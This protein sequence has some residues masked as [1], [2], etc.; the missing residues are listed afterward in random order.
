MAIGL[1]QIS[2]IVKEPLRAYSFEVEL[3]RDL[4]DADRLKYQVKSVQF[5]LWFNL[6]AEGVR[7]GG[8]GYYFLP[9]DFE[10]RGEVKVD[11]WE[12]VELSVQKYFSNWRKLMVVEDVVGTPFRE[13]KELPSKWMK[14]VVVHVLDVKGR[15]V[16]SYRLR[17][18]YPVSVDVISLG[19]ERSEVVEVSVSFVLH[20][21]EVIV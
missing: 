18:C 11:F 14:D 6:E 12:D 15:R 19:Y 21:V 20:G 10:G 8:V 1:V 16:G 17:K 9:D 3:P 7:V 4:G 5:P 2:G 13:L